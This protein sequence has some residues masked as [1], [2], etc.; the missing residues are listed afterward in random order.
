VQSTSVAVS[1][2]NFKTQTFQ[3]NVAG[4]GYIQIAQL[5]QNA[6]FIALGNMTF[7]GTCPSG[8]EVEAIAKDITVLLDADGTASITPNDLDDGSGDICGNPVT[9]SIDKSSF[10]CDDL[11]SNSI[12]FT[13]TRADGE[14][15]NTIATVTVKPT[16]ALSTSN[17]YLDANGEASFTVEEL[18]DPSITDCSTITYSIDKLNFTCADVSTEQNATLTAM[19]DGVV[20]NEITTP[21]T[22]LDS[23]SPKDVTTNDIT[24]T[25][26]QNTGL[27]VI[28]PETI[29]DAATDNCSSDFTLSLSKTTFNCSDEGENTVTLT[30]TDESGNST[31]AEAVVTINST[32]ID[33]MISTT[34]PAFCPDGSTTS[35]TID[36]ASSELGVKYYLRDSETEAILD[37]PIEGTGGALSFSAGSITETTTAYVFAESSIVPNYG[38]DF[39][40][41]DDRVATT[42]TQQSTSTLTFE[43]WIFPRSSSTNRILTNYLG[44]GAVFAG[45]IIID[46]YDATA[47][48]GTAL[49]IYASG[50]ENT[51]GIYSV[52]NVLTLNTWNHFAITFDNGLVKIYVDGIE[53]GSSTFSFSTIPLA[54]APFHIGEDR[55]GT[56]QEFF[57]GKMD[58]IRIWNVSKTATEITDDMNVRLEGTETGLVAYYNFDEGSGI[59]LTDEVNGANGTLTNMDPATDWILGA[60]GTNDNICAVRMKTSI[61]IGDSEVPT[62]LAKNINIQLDASGSSTVVASDLDNGSSDNCTSAENLTFTLDQSVFDCSMLGENNVLMTVADLAGNSST[63]SAIITVTL[64]ITDQSV[65]TETPTVCPGSETTINISSSQVGLNYFLRNTEKMLIEGPIEGTGQSMTFNTGSITNETTFNVFAEFLPNANKAMSLAGNSGYIE[66]PN[67]TSLQLDANWTIEA[68]V[69]PVGSLMN[70]VESYDANGG[71]VLRSNGSKWQAYAMQSSTISSIVT[72]ASSIEL[73]V[74]THL[75][76]TFNETTNEL[77]IYVNGVLD[78]TNANATIDQ[79]GTGTTIKLGARGDDKQVNSQHVQDEIR[80]WKVERSAKEISDHKSVGLAGNETGLVAYYDFNNMTFQTVGMTIEDKTANGNNGAMIG[81]YSQ[82]NIIEGPVVTTGDGCG[83]QMTTTQTITPI[84][85]EI[86]TAVVKDYTLILDQNG[87]G[88][89]STTDIDDGSSDNCTPTGDLV[90]SLD[91]TSFDIN[92]LGDNT[93]TLTVTDAS[94]NVATATAIV[95]VSDKEEQTATFTGNTDRTFGDEDFTIEATLDSSLPVVFTVVSGGLA[96]ASSTSESATFTITAAGPAVISV[97]NEGDNTYAPLQETITINV[98]K[99]DQV[100]TVEPISNM[101]QQ[102]QPFNVIASVNTNLTLD[103]AVSGPASISG[104]TVTLD[105]TL[106]TV[107]ITVS[108]EGTD[109]YNYVSET[110]TFDVIAKQAQTIT[111]S[112]IPDLTYGVEDQTLSATASSGLTVQFSLISGPAEL[113]GSTLLTITG[114]GDVVVEATQAG[115]D[116]FLEASTQQTFSV[117]KADLTIT[118]D[119]QSITYGEAIPSLTYQYAGFVNGESASVMISEPV[120]STEA[121][122]SSDVGTYTIELSGG[123]AANYNMT[124]QNGTL[125]IGKRDQLITIDPIA[126]KQSTDAAFEVVATIDSGLDLEYEVSGP[127][128]ISGTTIT[129]E[130]TE[131]TVTVTVSQAGDINHNAT[132]DTE[133]FEVVIPLS[134]NDM[135]KGITI[136]PNPTTDYLNFDSYEISSLRIYSMNGREELTAEDVSGRIDISHLAPGSYLVEL[137]I[138]DKKVTHR[139]IKAN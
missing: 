40:G 2:G 136:Y 6:P 10:T 67:S 132:L 84:D 114:V 20:I 49:R 44:S 26:D 19:H 127:A 45:D 72:S 81:Q 47:I 1:S 119:D 7:T 9:L 38:L 103:Y 24:V 36:M 29:Y 62:A 22:V 115:D 34:T 125:T 27:A 5:T 112:D 66:I 8:T 55:S 109:D 100:L 106:G 85:T 96:V 120:I 130:G 68:W 135:E 46:T 107:T 41:S 77:K 129:L 124:L 63:A 91:I 53:V 110:V 57:N 43:G 95:T 138:A 131:G 126:D 134:V 108:Q 75:A 105:G 48:N 71:F 64:G 32:I 117:S 86:P 31:T 3:F 13:A 97:T 89:I 137:M 80:I 73:D 50:A 56:T 93:V 60:F 18:L 17:V 92:N 4:S 104:S 37:G 133:S 14:S 118:A 42:F 98:A 54:T 74:W 123:E 87:S 116:D 139:I 28:T 25:L 102:A 52:P 122:G 76:A 94:G 30:V 23:I 11:G 113:T 79:R 88:S 51:I 61:T 21:L 70:I 39:D 99:A 121:T 59:T 15:D 58:E 83:I 82:S 16:L 111:F 90:L 128:T 69:K 12:S 35:A 33:Q 65:T 78:A 101:P